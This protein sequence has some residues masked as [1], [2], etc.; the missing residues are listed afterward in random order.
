[1]GLTYPAAYQPIST[2]DLVSGR[3]VRQDITEKMM[4]NYNRALGN[5]GRTLCNQQLC[6][7]TALVNYAPFQ[8]TGALTA[9]YTQIWSLYNEWSLDFAS[10]TAS[11]TAYAVGGNVTARMFIAAAATGAQVFLNGVWMTLTFTI[12][13]GVVNPA[14][15]GLQALGN[16]L[17]LRVSNVRLL[18]TPRASPL[19]AGAMASS[20]A[21]P[22]ELNL[23][24]QGEP[25]SNWMHQ[26]MHAGLKGIVRQR[27]TFWSFCGLHDTHGAARFENYFTVTGTT[28]TE[29]YRIRIR[30]R[31]PKVKVYG[32]ASVAAAGSICTLVVRDEATNDMVS[33][34]FAI[35]AALTS[36]DWLSLGQLDV[37]QNRYDRLIVE[38]MMNAAVGT[39]YLYGLCIRE[40]WT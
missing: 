20:G 23:A 39:G 16:G 38:P 12:P 21:V 5:Y 2:G 1:M 31:A 40:D 24:A 4:E 8:Q 10:I 6:G 15:I 14:P 36:A 26:Q 33:N 29:L 3:Y 18:F 19:P 9:G 17:N 34:N 32:L 11:V 25:L 37:R 7:S 22:M 13:R 27:P 30:S 35:P 28:Q